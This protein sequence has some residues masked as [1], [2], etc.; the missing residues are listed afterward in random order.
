MENEVKTQL[1]P[2]NV[3]IPRPQ[4]RPQHGS[5]EIPQEHNVIHCVKKEAKHT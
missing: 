4:R 1:N 5:V 2:K 3:E